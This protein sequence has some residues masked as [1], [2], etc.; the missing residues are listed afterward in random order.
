M[1]ALLP[2]LGA[3]PSRICPH[4]TL[5]IKTSAETC[6]LTTKLTPLPLAGRVERKRKREIMSE[7][8]N[9]KSGAAV[10]GA[11]PCSAFLSWFNQSEWAG[12]GKD[13]GELAR[14]A[15]NAAVTECAAAFWQHERTI[16]G[17]SIQDSQ[18]LVA[19]IHAVADTPNS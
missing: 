8:S 10:A 19:A 18:I 15:W 14:T 3:H 5:K 2:L 7:E 9:V 11:A 1:L 17:V 6:S 12:A 4:R 13:A 16:K